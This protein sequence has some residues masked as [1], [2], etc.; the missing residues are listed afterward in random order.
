MVLMN[1]FSGQE[2][3]YRWRGICAPY[4]DGL[5]TG[6]PGLQQICARVGPDMV[7]MA[8]TVKARMA[9][10]ADL[11]EAN[12]MNYMGSQVE[13]WLKNTRETV[14]KVK[15]VLS[16]KRNCAPPRGSARNW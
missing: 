9:V 3:R 14:T 2:W 11:G 6:V 8:C 13:R 15:K 7:M 10:F 5:P 4:T 12:K 16:R 1:L